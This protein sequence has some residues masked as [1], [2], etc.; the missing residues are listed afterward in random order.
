M[1]GCVLQRPA[2]EL[3]EKRLRLLPAESGH[4]TFTGDAPP[5]DQW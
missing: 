2:I 5:L 1:A 4:V 3:A